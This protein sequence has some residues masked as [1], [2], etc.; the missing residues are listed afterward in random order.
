[1]P[2]Q[3]TAALAAVAVLTLAAGPAR[4]ERPVTASANELT[5][6]VIGDTPYGA[7]QLEQFPALVVDIN[8]DPEVDLTLHVGDIKSGSTQ[9]SDAYFQ[10]ISSLSETF[11]DPLVYTPR[12]QRVDRLP[13][14]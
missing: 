10:T 7:E 9:C 11:K 5:L 8:A 3:V 6:A 14:A 13:P 2:R 12:R 1:M 4:A